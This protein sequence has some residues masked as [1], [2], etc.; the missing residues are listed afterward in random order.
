MKRC[1]GAEKTGRMVRHIIITGASRGIGAALAR[2]YAAPGVVLGLVARSREALEAIAGECR[3]RGAEVVTGALDIC[4]DA[5]LQEWIN[6]FDAAH[7]VDL[8]IAN[9]GVMGRAGPGQRLESLEGARQQ[10]RINLEGTVS[11]ATAM[12]AL[13]QQRKAGHIAIISSLAGHQPLPDSPAYSASKAGLTAWAE[14][15]AE[16]L[17]PDKIMVSVICPGFI[18]TEMGQQFPKWAPFEISAEKAARKIRAGLARRRSFI[19]FPQPLL[20]SARFGR[21][22]PWRIKRLITRF[23]RY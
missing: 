13:M 5:A 17:A 2:Q 9:A 19:S 21:L 18:D 12:A 7:S 15:L 10:F 23:F 8:L 22:F 16:F 1:A 11:T 14:A 4:D 6:A 3:Q 20:W